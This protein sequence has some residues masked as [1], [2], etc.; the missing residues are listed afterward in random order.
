M[1]RSHLVAN[2]FWRYL[3]QSPG[4]VVPATIFNAVIDALQ[5]HQLGGSAKHYLYQ[6]FYVATHHVCAGLSGAALIIL[7]VVLLAPRYF[8]VAEQRTSLAAR[9]IR[10]GRPEKNI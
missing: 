9:E 1:A 6:S 3:G 7:G 2:L 5:A 4:A 8:P 10:I